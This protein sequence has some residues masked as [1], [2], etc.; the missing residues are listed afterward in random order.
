MTTPIYHF[1]H[2]NNL[3]GILGADSLY[4]KNKLPTDTQ[5]VDI[6]LQNLQEK[7]RNRRVGCGPGGILHDYVPFLFATRSPMMFLISRGGVEGRSRNTTPLIYLVSSVERVQESGL[8]FVFS[9]GHPIVALSRFY[10]DAAELD[11][12]DWQVM[13]SRYWK[14]TE[15]DVDRERRRQAEFLIHEALPWE[16]V[17][18]LAVKNSDL[19]RRLEQY[20][21]GEWPGRMKPVRVEPG[22][23]FS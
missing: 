4:C 14:D 12:V 2:A 21:A 11:K 15:E 18:F 20:L 6:S 7:R 19:K 23:Y 22:W 1:T 10:D 5:I 13:N 8:S 16:L 3:P 9:D 17:E